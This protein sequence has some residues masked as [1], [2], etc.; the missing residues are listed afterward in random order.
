MIFFRVPQ[1]LAHA[2]AVA[3]RYRG[4]RRFKVL[5]QQCQTRRLG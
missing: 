4:Q 2:F 3:A 1:L 5:F